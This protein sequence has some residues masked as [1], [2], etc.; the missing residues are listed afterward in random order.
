[1]SENPNILEG[2]LDE[3]AY[4]RQLG[5]TQRT[6]QRAR[7]AGTAPPHVVLHRQVFYIIDATRQDFAS[8]AVAPVRRPHRDGRSRRSTSYPEGRR[9]AEALALEQL[10]SAP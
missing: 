10:K 6:A 8:R 3:A 2:L 5:I 7:R 1:M 9:Q 4:C